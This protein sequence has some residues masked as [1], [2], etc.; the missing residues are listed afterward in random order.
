MTST[1]T[2]QND[3]QVA[4]IPNPDIDLSGALQGHPKLHP[5]SSQNTNN[6]MK[7]VKQNPVG[8]FMGATISNCTI[9]INMPK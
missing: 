9:N 1:V 7:I 2:K 6:I 3:I 4:L 5:T 8:L